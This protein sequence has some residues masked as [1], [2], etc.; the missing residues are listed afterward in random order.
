MYDLEAPAPYIYR[1]N[2]FSHVVAEWAIAISVSE[3]IAMLFSALAVGLGFLSVGTATI[4]QNGQERITDY[5]DTTI[6]PS[7]GTFRTYDADA[8]EIHYMGRWD[9]KHVSYWS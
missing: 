2:V 6:S 4:W 1:G 5:P 3:T 8:K 9:S 7:N